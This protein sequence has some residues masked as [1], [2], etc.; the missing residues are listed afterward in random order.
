M[1]WQSASELVFGRCLDNRENLQ[2][3]QATWFC[4]PYND[5]FEKLKDGGTHTDIVRIISVS[6]YEAAIHAAQSLNGA[7]EKVDWANILHRSAKQN[8]VADKF[9]RVSKK[10]RKGQEVDIIPAIELARDLANPDMTGLINASTIEYDNFNEL[11]RSGW[12]ALDYNLGGIPH[13]A[14][15]VV[16]GES[17]LGKS[18]WSMIFTKKFLE[19]YPEKTAVI[20]SLEMPAQQYLQR[21]VKMYDMKDLIDGGRIYISDKAVTIDDIAAESATIPS[22]GLIVC[23]YV[24]YLVSQN[25]EDSYARVYKKTNEICRTLHIPFCMI[26]QPNRN[27]YTDPVPRA[28]HIRYS[29]MAEN[30]ASQIIM[31]WKPRDATMTEDNYEELERASGF[32]FCEDSM[33]MVCWKNRAG[34]V[35]K[36]E[37]LDGKSRQGPGAIVLPKVKGIWADEVGRWLIYGD[38]PH[39]M[40]SIRKR[41]K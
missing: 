23:D 1:D 8:E 26:V 20:Y 17:G 28:Y 22:L 13:A 16:G 2:K 9:D 38:V 40:K 34:W 41:T 36:D 30:V 10:L 37:S 7:G 6:S 5:A 33:Y 31:L 25:N 24:D 39:K 29:G 15:L 4:E 27:Q 19:Y 11:I 12:D 32:T 35:T 3:F 14:P 21:A 18:F